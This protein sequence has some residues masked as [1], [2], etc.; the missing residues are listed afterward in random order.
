MNLDKR[1]TNQVRKPG[2]N[3][4]LQAHGKPGILGNTRAQDHG[5]MGIS[6]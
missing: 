2:E 3:S 5:W 1:D 6:N 4:A